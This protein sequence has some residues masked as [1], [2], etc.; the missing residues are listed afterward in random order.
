[1]PAYHCNVRMNSKAVIHARRVTKRYGHRTVLR[2]VDLSVSAGQV[3]GIVGENG[4][5]KSTLLQILAGVMPPTSGDVERR[6]SIGYCP[7]DAL[8]FD[9]LTV[10]ENLRFFGTAVGLTGASFE[11]RAESLLTTLAL[12]PHRNQIVGELSGGSKQKLNLV[13]ALLDDPTVLLL[14]EPCSGLDWETYLSF[15][16]LANRARDMGKS[17]VIVSHLIHERANFDIVCDLRQ[18]TLL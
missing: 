17:V 14:D 4:C 16:V 11:A 9:A 6:G 3:V 2:D 13:V 5:G 8:V 7:Q 1:M 12:Q 10:V 18:G 15:W